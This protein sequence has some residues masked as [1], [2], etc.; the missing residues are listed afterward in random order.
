MFSGW[1][2]C[3]FYLCVCVYIVYKL[4]V[5]VLGNVLNICIYENVCTIERSAKLALRVFFTMIII[6]RFAFVHLLK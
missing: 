5:S 6:D 2:A 1:S 3:N 4:V